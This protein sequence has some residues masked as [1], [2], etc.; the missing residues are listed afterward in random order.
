MEKQFLL[1][2]EKNLYFIK[3]VSRNVYSKLL[4]QSLILEEYQNFNYEQKKEIIF[5]K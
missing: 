1:I 5:E 2:K 3:E 4:C